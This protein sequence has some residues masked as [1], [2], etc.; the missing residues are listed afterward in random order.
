MLVRESLTDIKT[1]PIDSAQIRDTVVDPDGK[2]TTSA[3]PLP[4]TAADAAESNWHVRKAPRGGALLVDNHLHVQL[5]NDKGQVAIMKDVFALGD[6]SSLEINPIPATAQATRQEARWLATRLNNGD[7]ESSPP[8]SFQNMGILAY[9]GNQQAM[10][11]LPTPEAESR[12]LL[13]KSIKGKA[14]WMVWNSA[15]IGMSISWKNKLRLMFRWS[16]N[17]LF[18]RDV[19]RF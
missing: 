11:Q 7:L 16:I 13:P 10:M 19:A 17:R 5:E 1:F 9:L 15:Y 3:A 4:P 14:A 6:N 8:F 18:G 2:T 12:S